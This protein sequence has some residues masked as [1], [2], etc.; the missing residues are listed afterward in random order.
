MNFSLIIMII[1]CFAVGIILMRGL[2]NMMQGG[3]ANTSQRLMRMRVAAQAVAILV[4][5]VVVYLSR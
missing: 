4:I 5:V 2:W 1:A 3:S